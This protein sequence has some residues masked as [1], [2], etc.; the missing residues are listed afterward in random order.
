MQK[1]W[2]LVT[3]RKLWNQNIMRNSWRPWVKKW[4]P[5][6]SQPS[7]WSENAHRR[8]TSRVVSWWARNGLT[9]LWAEYCWDYCTLQ[10]SLL[11]TRFSQVPGVGYTFAYSNTIRHETL[12]ALIAISSLKRHR[13]T[14]GDKQAA[15]TY[16]RIHKVIY[17]RQPIIFEKT[18]KTGERLVYKLNRSIY[19]LRQS[20]AFW[21]ESSLRSPLSLLLVR[22]KGDQVLFLAFYVSMT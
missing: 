8:H 16:G 7:S 5:S 1:N 12:R 13:I 14:G 11:C 10:S 20:G 4:V 22:G 15:Y 21:N 2:F 18:V 19:C 6:Q 17:M 3:F 9:T